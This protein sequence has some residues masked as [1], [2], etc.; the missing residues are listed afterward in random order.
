MEL[1]SSTTMQIRQWLEYI[2]ATDF[3]LSTLLL[4]AYFLSTDKC[5][6][7]DLENQWSFL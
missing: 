3:F 4:D 6:L 2:S 5:K 1:R 7:L